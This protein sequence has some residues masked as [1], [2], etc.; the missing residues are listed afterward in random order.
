M[1]IRKFG[2]KL[3]RHGSRKGYRPRLP[4]ETRTKD[5]EFSIGK[6]MEDLRDDALTAAGPF[7][8]RTKR[9]LAQALG[10]ASTAL[11]EGW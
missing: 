3:I 7:D 8:G 10:A 11:P 2:E 6:L 5:G 1:E 9:M 4:D